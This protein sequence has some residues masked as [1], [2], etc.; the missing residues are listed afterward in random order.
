[1][2]EPAPPRFETAALL[3]L[4]AV[5][6]VNLLDFMM[7]MP[8]GPDFAK[9]LGIPMSSLGV[10]G[11]SYTAAATVVGL[12]GSFLLDRF[13]RR[14]ALAL[15]VVGLGV[16]TMAGALGTGT[17]SLAAARAAAGSF[18]GVAATLCFSI[19]ADIVPESR[20]GRATAVVASGFSLAAIFGL[21]AGLELARLG[22]WR[23]P[24]VIVGVLALL[25]AAVA[26]L[27]LPPLRGHLDAAVDDSPLRLDRRLALAFMAFGF[28]LL[29]N[30]LL[31]PNLSAYVQ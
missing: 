12:A 7:V 23:A 26:R 13:E 6:F 21:P 8:L 2:P 17:W 19:V 20:R 11:G 31:V 9:A 4:G 30:F 27:L 5:H 24:F 10:I 14:A 28:A 29:G 16:A 15:N 3:V 25:L 18:G 1:M 22:G